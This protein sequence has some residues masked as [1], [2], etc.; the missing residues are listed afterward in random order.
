MPKLAT[1]WR[2]WSAGASPVLSWL[3][4]WLRG[5]GSALVLAL[6]ALLAVTLWPRQTDLIADTVWHS[7][8]ASLGV[9]L[10]T[11]LVV[12]GLV[13][14][15][16]ITICLSPLLVLATAAAFL[17]GWIALGWLV[18]RRLLQALKAKEVAP[19]WEAALGVFLLTLLG[20]VPCIGWLAWV[21][22]GAF[23]L[24]AVVLTRF[25]TRRYNG[26]VPTVAA[27]QGPSD[28]ELTD[29]EELMSRVQA[30]LGGTDDDTGGPEE[31]PDELSPDGSEGPD[32]MPVGADQP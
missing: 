5:F 16:I 12:L 30:R 18:G 6:L 2:T 3:G 24:G 32:A 15:L 1:P 7:P 13:V 21:V 22:G 9:G 25:G 27:G 31:T 29:G 23:G 14:L 4:S 8:A 28:E 19:I 11:Y 26:G 10:L 17:I 20:T